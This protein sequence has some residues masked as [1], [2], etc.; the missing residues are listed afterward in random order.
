MVVP[1]SVRTLCLCAVCFVL[2]SCGHQ[3]VLPQPGSQK[4]RE[5]V[6]AFNVGLSALQCSEDVRA[7]SRL[8]E[9]SQIAPAE[10]A[11]WADL[12][13][14]AVRQQEFDTALRNMT[15]AHELA[16]DN[17]RIEFYLGEIESKRG[18][19]PE[20]TQHFRRAVELDS[21]N[22]KA[23]Y[24]LAQET[25]RQATGS[26]DADAL[27]YL[28]KILNQRPANIAVLVDVARLAAK[29]GD[30]VT[31]KSAVARLA[32]L[33][34]AWP[35][36][37]QQQMKTLEQAAQSANP[38]EAALRVAFLRNVLLRV[39]EY[40]RNSDAVKTPPASAGEPFVKFMKLPSPSSEPAP[41]D[42]AMSFVSEAA[43]DVAP[44]H[45]E[46]LRT[47]YLDGSGKESVM[48]SDGRSVHITGGATINTGPVGRN[49]VAVADLNF[50]FKNDL[51]AAGPKGLRIYQQQDTSHFTDVTAHTHLPA[52]VINGAY[53]GAWPFDFDLDGDLDIVLGVSGAPPLV[54]RNNGDGTFAAVR[55]FSG[56]VGV[57]SLAIGDVAGVTA[58]D[59]AMVGQ[60]GRLTLFMN[61][62]H[63]Q[64]RARAVP[65]N[66]A[67]GVLAVAEGDVDGDGL[68]D[69]V[70][71]KSDGS[72]IRLSDKNDGQKWDTGELLK[73][74]PAG[75]TVSNARLAVADFDNNG[76]L[77]L[78]VGD[79]QIFL[80]SANGFTRL[81]NVPPIA[82]PA[83]LDANGDGQLDLIGLSTTGT[84]VRLIN[85][86]TRHYQWQTIRLRAATVYGDQRINSFGLGGEIEI[87]TGMLTE[88]E[89]IDAPV[90]HFGLGEHSGTDVARIL[91]P[92]GLL[93][94]EFEL[95]ADQDVLAAQRLKGS[96]PS[97]FAWDGRRMSFVKDSAPL[98][99]GLGEEIPR[100]EEWYKL[101]G[102]QIQPRDGY[103]DI[104]VTDELWESYYV[105]S[106]SL[107][108]VDHPQGTEIW[109]DE[110]FPLPPTARIYATRKPR[111]FLKVTDDLGHDVSQ[112]VSNVDQKYL[113]TF[114]RGRYQGVTRDHWVEVELPDE[115][116]RNGPLYLIADGW[117]HPTDA[118]IDL[119]MGQGSQPKEEGLRI[120]APDAQGRWVVAQSKL[121]FPASKMK[122]MV[123]DLTG[124]F[125]P[126]APR[127]LRLATNMEIFWDR[128][129]WAEGLP[130]ER[131]RT[132]RLSLAKAELRHRGFSVMDVA[133]ASSPEIPDYNRL[134][135]TGQ[136]WPAI[137][138]YYTR[139]GDV[140]ELLRKSDDRYVIM[141]SG[142][143]VCLRFPAASP[144]S[145]GWERDFVMIGDG[146][147][148][149]GDFNSAYS[150]TVLPLPYH[151]MKGY[152]TPPGRLED[153]H[154]Y[155]EHPGDWQEFHTRYMAPE[156]FRSALWK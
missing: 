39:P 57:S 154:A 98:A 69:F 1:A 134:E 112:A 59:I 88:K 116:P 13:L 63:G 92:N 62:R 121:G 76:S 42:L 86:G 150:R 18:N 58:P 47:F 45:V 153:D 128:L 28:K 23:L 96:C 127:K 52:D 34:T 67:E 11:I 82:G 123:I 95:K 149:D 41:P 104:R 15:K 22:I 108:V 77:D 21:A 17:S 118:S 87:R 7:K 12:G 126:N 146:W 14:L 19:L 44:G 143:E 2:A 27:G 111:P 3:S 142:D 37:V 20:A 79:G 74:N 72:V 46:W 56:P 122:T 64:Y 147:I 138:G 71:W 16:P 94:V 136:K 68:L 105:D 151:A 54:L 132:Q 60:D 125:R 38:R 78:V 35:A 84:S 40:R 43:A 29:T 32:Q 117:M 73:A 99:T 145:A 156:D 49:G 135:G 30:A 65:P 5:L 106:Y 115:A 101:P 24:S 33:S 80:G 36:E 113:D 91:W 51:V 26:S 133:D 102:S 48:W 148:K 124:V 155:R 140:L 90:V 93:Q 144:P 83:I 130:D 89:I 131:I 53:T 4:Y 85:H 75:A 70:V 8:T 81:N 9:A 61:E 120:L 114:G 141:G 100:T 109:S 139:Y 119:A 110:R 152:A 25:E 10:P 137:E 55:P 6:H 129:A 50:D 107:L 103:Y 66:V 97:L 31:L